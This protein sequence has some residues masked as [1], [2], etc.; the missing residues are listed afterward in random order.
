VRESHSLAPQGHGV[1]TAAPKTLKVMEIPLE[2]FEEMT[3]W[4]KCTS[5]KKFNLI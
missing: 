1:Q 3:D 2:A 4:L 5:V